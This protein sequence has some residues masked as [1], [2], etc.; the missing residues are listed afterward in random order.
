MAACAGQPA[1]RR[2]EVAEDYVLG[3]DELEGGYKVQGPFVGEG[4][5]GRF[6]PVAAA[7]AAASAA[8]LVI[9]NGLILAEEPVQRWA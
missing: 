7:A 2:A 9:K 3:V 6:D 4:E 5:K 1:V 8:A